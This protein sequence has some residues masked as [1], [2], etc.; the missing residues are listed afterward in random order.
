MCHCSPESEESTAPQ[1]GQDSQQSRKSSETPTAS[2]CSSG[3]GRESIGVQT[4]ETSPI[5]SSAQ[6]P[7]FPGDSPASRSARPGS[8]V[9]REMTATSGQRCLESYER[10][11]PNG[12]WQKTFLASCLLT[13][14]WSSRLCYLTWSLRATKHSRWYVQLRARVPRTLDTECSLLPT[15]SARDW[16]NG[17]A[18]EATKQRNSRP[19]NEVVLWPTPTGVTDTGGA[20]LCKWGG[21]G[22]RKKLKA[23]VDSETLNGA[24]NPPFVEW[25]QGFPIGW[26]D[27]EP[28]V[29]P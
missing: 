10:L 27:C 3:T 13:E 5:E 11:H 15:A 9:A 22:A 12:S 28:S 24:L 6:L 2:R 26:T 8:G 25:L 7:L 20:A 14:A 18:S 17:K 19:L 4:S 21:S 23:M 29:T 16:K 1:N